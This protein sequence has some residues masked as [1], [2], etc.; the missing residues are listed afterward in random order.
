MNRSWK[1]KLKFEEIE[2]ADRRIEQAKRDLDAARHAR[3]ALENELGDLLW[4]TNGKAGE[5]YSI[6]CDDD[7]LITAYKLSEGQGYAVSALRQASSPAPEE[8]AA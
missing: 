8:A 3:S 4:P 1:A 5:R 6:W 7:L 2:R